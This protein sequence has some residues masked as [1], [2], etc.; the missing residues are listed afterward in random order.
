MQFSSEDY[1]RMTVV[2]HPLDNSQMQSRA[3]C[4]ANL[5]QEENLLQWIRMCEADVGPHMLEVTWADGFI[6]AKP[7]LNNQ[8]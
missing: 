3:E 7:A 8:K 6:H 5:L 1:G 2:R 4:L